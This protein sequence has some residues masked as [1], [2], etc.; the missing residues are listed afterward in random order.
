MP[1][2]ERFLDPDAGPV[3]SLAADLRALRRQFG[4]PGYRQL[5]DRVGYS[6]SAL[7]NAAGGRQLPSLAVTLAFVQA[8]GGETAG[9]EQQ[10]RRA[11]AEWAVR[12]A[13]G[14][15]PSDGERGAEPPYR[16]LAGYGVGDA[17]R[18]FGRDRLVAQLVAMLSTRRFVAVFGVSG[19]G[20]SSLLRAGLIPALGAEPGAPGAIEETARPWRW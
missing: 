13:N 10:W 6:V 7:A 18:F 3:Q 5:A 8:C 15:R 16:G 2:P 17:D 4:N 14:S 1:R 12:Q 19:S 9:W 11:A 20:K